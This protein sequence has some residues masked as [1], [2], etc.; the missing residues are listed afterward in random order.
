MADVLKDLA[1]AL[2]RVAEAMDAETDALQAGWRE[3]FPDRAERKRALIEAAEALV[4]RA[5]G[6]VPD[7]TERA[8][9]EVAARRLQAA[10]RRNLAA[11]E[12]AL[13]AARGV[14]ACLTDAA[15]TASMSGTY[16][17]DGRSR[18]AP[19]AVATVE[20]SA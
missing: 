6:R 12:R 18:P 19:E 8:D 3:D 20:R 13:E 14:V 1:A 2:E 5:Q 10:S 16:G 15:R 11:L 9:L 4:G 17:P 7:G